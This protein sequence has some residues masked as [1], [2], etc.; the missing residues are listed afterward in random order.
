MPRPFH[1]FVLVFAVLLTVACSGEGQPDALREGRTIYGDSC[2]VCHGPRGEGEVGPSLAE[3][4]ETWPSCDA[5]VEWIEIGSQGWIER[6]GD[7]Y[8]AT[9]K[10][11]NGGMPAHSG[12]LTLEE[13]RLVA[14]FERVEYGGQ[15]PEVALAECDVE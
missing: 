6:Y 14:A 7:R 10:S 15:E 12:T 3:V 4:V 8:G 1:A 5:Q 2:S 13:M 11:V 9:S